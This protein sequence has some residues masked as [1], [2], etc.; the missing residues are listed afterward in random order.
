MTPVVRALTHDE[1]L[2]RLSGNRLG[3]VSLS[4]GALPVI[5]P[6]VYVRDGI[7]VMFSAPLD[8]DFAQL[9][10]TSVIA[11]E[12]DGVSAS[13]DLGWSV[14]VVGVAS[15]LK[16]HGSDPDQVARVSL[17]RLSGQTLEP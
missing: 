1:C 8:R 9:C 13:G 7:S 16:D 4:K 17:G 11:F 12:V 14:Q 6:V 15:A 3:R 10:D 5:V 2:A